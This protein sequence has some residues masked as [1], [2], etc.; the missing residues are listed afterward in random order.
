MDDVG[1]FHRFARAYDLVMPGA[2]GEALGRGL[3]HAERALDRVVDLAGGP[4]RALTAVE[5]IRGPDGERMLGDGLVVDAARGMTRRARDNG[6]AAIQGD[7][8]KLP[9]R[10][11]AVDAI[12]IVDALHHLPDRNGAIAAAARALA[13][14]G[15]LVVQEFDPTTLRGRALAGIERAV[16][17][18][19]SFDPAAVLCERL[20]RA[21]LEPVVV[22]SGFSYVVAGVATAVDRG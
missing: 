19:S 21:G 6:H 8:G 7:A 13:P 16:G 22:D 4:G 3:A 17:F 9:L 1:T 14:G 10:D 12:L 11:G 20:E 15:V 5:G 2:D 18:D